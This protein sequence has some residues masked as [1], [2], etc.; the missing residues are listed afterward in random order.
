MSVIKVGL[1]EI[2]VSDHPYPVWSNISYDGKR[3]ER[4]IHHK[5]LRDLAY[6]AKRAMQAARLALKNDSNEV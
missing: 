3:I 4:V 5:D 1:W 2:D 6:A